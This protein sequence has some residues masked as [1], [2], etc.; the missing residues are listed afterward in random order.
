MT[1]FEYLSIATS[2]VMA[3]GLARLLN[4]LS[5][6]ARHRNGYWVHIMW[7]VH[8]SLTHLMFWWIFWSYRQ[9]EWSLSNFVLAFGALCALYFQA[10]SLV[11]DDAGAVRDWKAYY[12]A[13]RRPYFAAM[14]AYVL[15]LAFNSI[16]TR[17]TPFVHPE[18]V[19]QGLLFSIALLGFLCRRDRVQEA[20]VLISIALIFIGIFSIP[21]SPAVAFEFNR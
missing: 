14:M 12:D 5:T 20:L 8:L 15:I 16:L 10:T 13:E 7:T 18:R 1:H 17:E 19:I 21:S 3:L 11:P 9:A 2:I 6:I 4:G